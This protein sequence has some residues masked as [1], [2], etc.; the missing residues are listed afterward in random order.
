MIGL[1]L[2]PLLILAILSLLTEGDSQNVDPCNSYTVLNDEWRSTNNI[3][4]PVLHCDQYINWQGWYRLFLG[5]SNARIPESCIDTNRCGTHAPLWI[6][7]PHP[8]QPGETVTRT[9]CNNWSGSC[10]YF[11]S[12]TIQVKLCHGN[13]YVYK[14]ER[15]STCHL[16]YCAE[17]YTPVVPSVVDSI[18][19]ATG[20]TIIDVH[21]QINSIQDRCAYS[22]FST[23]S[24]PDFLV[25]GNFRDRRRKDV[26]FLDSVTLR[27]DGHYIHLEQGGRVQLDDST[28]TLDSSSQ[29]VHGVQLSK[30]QTGVTA[31]LS[32]SNL[33]IS[34]FFDGDTAQILLEG[35]AGSSV[36]GLCGNSRSSLSDLRIS[37]Y[38]STSCEMQ[39]SETADS[40]ID[41]NSVTERCNLLKEAP[42][43][44][45]NSDIDP[46]PYITACTDTLCKYP[47]VDGLNCQFLKA[48]ARACTLHNHAL[49]GWTSKTGCSSEAFCQDRTCSDHEFCGEK[50]VGGDTRCFCR[51]IFASKYQANNSFGDPTVCMQDSA[52]VTLVGCLLEDK[53]IDYSA[54]HLNDPT[55]RGQV[56]ELTHMVTFSF[57]S[58]NSCGTVVTTNNSELIYKNT[59][60]TQNSSS[61]IITR[62]DQVYID[63]SCVQTQ[64]D[65]K[66]ATFRIRDSSVIQHITSGVWDYTLTM[67]AFTDAGRTQ[68]VESSTEVQLNQKIW[69]ELKTDGLDGD[70]VAVVTDSCWATDQ[71]SPDSSPRY[72]LI[73]N[74]CANPA[75][76]TVQVEENGLG[77][78]NYFSFNMFEF[79]GGSGE[80]FLHCKLHVCP[81]QNNCVPTC[82]GAARR[83]RSARSKYE[84]EAFIS[85]TWT[86]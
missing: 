55:C 20:P 33:I 64:P 11:S 5:S 39:Y 50:T 31:K 60:M 84:G 76:Q 69:V 43:S 16:A 44:S 23:P 9:V 49:D 81:K 32:L 65:I 48:Y 25:L 53:G 70:M 68:A 36:E 30:D 21:G 22:L 28:L 6:T 4:N 18:C 1:M 38:S 13:Y 52:S 86:H 73:I 79:T 41:C 54:L 26:S 34:V 82:P 63:F 24:L 85:M 83:R 71:P 37:E 72:D 75:D 40:T 19:T 51:D 67:K 45:C 29:L 61:D 17:N 46:E 2:H 15:P 58:S 3:N 62:H 12:H 57:N 80:V 42:F 77:T 14:L 7:Q 59:I 27:V 47:A 8:T 78:S 56:D 74:G 66:T 10:C 35:P